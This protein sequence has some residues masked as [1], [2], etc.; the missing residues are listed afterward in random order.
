MSI[1]VPPY[2]AYQAPLVPLR[3]LWSKPPPEG[4]RYVNGEIDW[5]VTTT[6]QLAVAVSLSGNSPVAISQIIALAVDNSR[7]G[8]PV[9]FVFS[10][11]GFALNVP[12]RNQGIYPVF[13]NA[14]N[15]Y[16]VSA[17]SHLGDVTSFTVLNSMPPP[18]S[19]APVELQDKALASGVNLAINGSTIILPATI[20]GT[21]EAFDFDAVVTAPAAGTCT[22]TLQDGQG[23][24]LWQRT[25]VA[26][27]QV[28]SSQS[29]LALRFVNGLVLV[30]AGT[31]A[32]TGTL[33][34]N[35]YYA[36]P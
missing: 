1:I 14:L 2:V 29:G 21:L 6:G 34:L 25:I 24:R 17:S 5:G 28:S 12:A 22:V 31:T 27:A 8:A 9:S 3:G 35:I 36:V 13:T 16:V 4:D 11:S 19:I 26:A 33:N 7:S 32:T 18:L 20:T 30:V 15:F 10:D 23:T